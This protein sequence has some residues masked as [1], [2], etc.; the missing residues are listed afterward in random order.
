MAAFLGLFRRDLSLALRQG[1]DTGLVIGFFVLA[2]VL[3]P[4]GVGPE[5]EVLQR[6][7]AGIIWVAAL[8][9]G[10]AVASDSPVPIGLS[11]WRAR[12]AGPFEP[13]ARACG[14]RKMRGALGGNRSAAGADQPFSRALGQSRSGVD[15]DPVRSSLLIGTPALSLIGQRRRGA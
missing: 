13:P 5:P 3:F 15:R 10:L 11:G 6:I 4:F 8:L 7:G 9:A 2:V 14:A 12:S 1:G